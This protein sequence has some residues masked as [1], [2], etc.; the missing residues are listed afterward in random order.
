ME[1]LC[2]LYHRST[3]HAFHGCDEY[4]S[5]ATYIKVYELTSIFPALILVY[6]I[7]GMLHFQARV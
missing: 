1:K 5:T 2:N 7:V 3:L 4:A 6:L